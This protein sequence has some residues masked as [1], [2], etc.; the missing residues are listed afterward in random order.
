MSASDFRFPTKEQLRRK[1]ASFAMPRGEVK[2]AA[3]GA[4]EDTA[5]EQA[6]SNIA[7]EYVKS[8]APKILDYEIGFQVLNKNEENTKAVGIIGAKVGD[9]WIYCP[10]FFLNGRMKGDEL[11]YIKS[12]DLF[13]PLDED[14]VN[15][16]LNKRPPQLGENV[17]RNLNE[18]GVSSPNFTQLRNSPYKFASGDMPKFAAEAV[19]VLGYVAYTPIDEAHPK[20]AGQAGLP[21]FV[22]AAGRKGVTALLEICKSFPKVAQAIDEF[23]GPTFLEDQVALVKKSD[24]ISITDNEGYGEKYTPKKVEKSKGLID[25]SD[26]DKGVIDTGSGIKLRT[27]TNEDFARKAVD[28]LSEPWSKEK[29][30]ECLKQGWAIEDSRSD[31]EVSYAFDVKSPVDL[32]N[33]SET[34]VYEVLMRPGDFEKCLIIMSPQGSEANTKLCSVIR[35]SD[36]K[37]I[38]THPNRVWTKRV[39]GPGYWQKWQD[40]LE[41]LPKAESLSEG[42]TVVLIG[43]R[44]NGTFPFEVTEEWSTSEKGGK[45][46]KVWFREDADIRFSHPVRLKWDRFENTYGYDNDQPADKVRLTGRD[47]I[48]FRCSRGELM[49]PTS[50]RKL[51]LKSRDDESSKEKDKTVGELPLGSISDLEI[52]ARNATKALKIKADGSTVHINDSKALDKAAAVVSLV[53]DYGLREKQALECLDIA[54]QRK[55]GEFRLLKSAFGSPYPGPEQMMQGGG[56]NAPTFPDPYISGAQDTSDYFGAPS[57]SSAQFA[58]PINDLSAAHTDLSMYDPRGPDSAAIQMAQQAAQSGQKDVFETG[59]MTSMLRVMKSDNMVDRYLGD[60]IKGMDRLGRILF[61]LYWHGQEFAE[62]YGK[63]DM[64]DLED[65]LRNGFEAIG[66]IIIKLKQKAVQTDDLDGFKSNIEDVADMDA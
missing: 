43:E 6:F 38:N 16:L 13:V 3:G 23:Y 65:A 19:P 30:A 32:K 42:D 44:G 49:V 47:G 60:I 39:N 15:D 20:Y 63:Q 50:F 7:H 58:S 34:G 2:F 17:G 12:K 29:K 31:D 53:K 14:W 4:T 37:W 36:K 28:L 64:P 10:V 54:K 11:M 62:R 66:N 18:L 51:V 25:L 1:L 48:K 24:K 33:P 5:F 40:E 56:P 57:I 8:R 41:N 9:E 22:Q 26:N 27:M 35:L 52:F 61:N 59:V 45:L 46:Y 21:E 55:V